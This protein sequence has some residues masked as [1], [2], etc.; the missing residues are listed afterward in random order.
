M[1][2]QNLPHQRRKIARILRCLSLKLTPERGGNAD[3]KLRLTDFLQ[4]GGLP[5]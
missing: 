5:L 3:N 1:L 4:H 2:D